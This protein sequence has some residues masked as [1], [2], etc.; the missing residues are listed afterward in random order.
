[1]KAMGLDSVAHVGGG[2]NA[3]K[4]AGGVVEG[5]ATG[6]YAAKVSEVHKL[7]L[8][9][10]TPDRLT[11]EEGWSVKQVVGHLLDSCSN[12]HQRLCRSIPG[13]ELNFPA[14]DQNS[15][16][17]TANY[18][19]Y[20]YGKLVQLWF[21]YNGLLLHIYESM[22]TEVAAQTRIKVGDRPALT[23]HELLHF[24]FEHMDVHV[25]QIK[26]ALG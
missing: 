12:N 2:I 14:Y 23:V 8:A 5:L 4:A 1:M 24:Y 7:L 17:A 22:D 13:E 21:T 10:T 19:A 15:F 18:A 3:W 6:A 11:E 25:A 26:K 9:V 16:M 20:D